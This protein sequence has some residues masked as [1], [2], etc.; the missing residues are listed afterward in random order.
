MPEIKEENKSTL[1]IANEMVDEL[2]KNQEETDAR[3]CIKS[4]EMAGI[5]FRDSREFVENPPAPWDW[6]VQDLIA[7]NMKGDLNAKSKQ[8]KS[9]FAIQM[10]ICVANGK[11]FLGLSVPKAR[12]T[13][14]FNL[15]LMDRGAWERVSTIEE[16]LELKTAPDMLS[17]VNLRGASWALRENADK[18]ALAIKSRGIEFVVLDPRYKLICEGEDENNA[19]GLRGVLNFRDTLAKVAAVLMVG[20]DPKGDVAGKSMA[21]RGAGSYTAGADYDFSFAL[22]PHEVDGAS[23]LSISSRYRPSPKDQTIKFDTDSLIF[24]QDCDTPP[25]VKVIPTGHAATRTPEAKA[26][27][28]LIKFQELEAAVKVFFEKN[29]VMS[30]GKFRQKIKTTKAGAAYGITTLKDAIRTLLDNG[31][32]AKTPEKTLK[33]GKVKLTRERTEIVGTPDQ[34]SE[35]DKFF[36][37]FGK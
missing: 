32:I 11:D 19:A 5:V 21:D 30:M 31:T 1:E 8:W 15:E 36:A 33:D 13:A 6:I 12:K 14:Y 17:I 24:S 2:K 4:L 35:Y 9:F 16:S 18:L 34:I 28:N 29:T 26:D 20:H 3:N 25:A 22:S 10:A 27:K 37:T 7:S 23:V